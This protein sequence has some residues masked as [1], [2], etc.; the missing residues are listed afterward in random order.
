MKTCQGVEV[1]ATLNP[2]DGGSTVLQNIGIQP[3]HY[4]YMMQQ[5]R[6]LQIPN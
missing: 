3:P 6:K 2:E 1:Q 5:P 4:T